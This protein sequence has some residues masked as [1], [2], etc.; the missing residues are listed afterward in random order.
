MR[1]F[2]MVVAG[3]IAGAALTVGALLVLP[4]A[5]G[6]GERLPAGQE[7]TVRAHPHQPVLIWQPADATGLPEIPCDITSSGP[8]SV[9]LVSSGLTTTYPVY[10]GGRWWRV[11]QTVKVDPAG[12]YA[13]ACPGVGDTAVIVGAA[14]R[15]YQVL[16]STWVQRATLG[17]A[18]NL[19]AAA[20]FAV[21]GPLVAA[22]IMVTAVRRTRRRPAQS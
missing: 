17:L 12:D 14:P 13:L 6:L 4:P 18:S 9:E 15:A 21:T 5:G 2:W 1:L 7:V 16:D 3:L 8:V 22:V 20:A 11:L 10:A 19:L